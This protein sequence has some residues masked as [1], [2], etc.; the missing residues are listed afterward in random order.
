VH[1]NIESMAQDFDEGSFWRKLS[2]FARRAGR[3]VIER[4]LV[5]YYCM[6][7]PDTPAWA[8]RVIMGALAY[9]VLPV[10][11]VPDILP[12]AG[13][14]DDFGVL[15]SALTIVLT[16]I[17]P[18]HWGQAERKLETWFGR[19]RRRDHPGSNARYTS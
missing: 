7:D 17:K 15:A 2:R 18:D 19:G 11:I 14:A 1:E 3:R 10:D 4:V 8:R 6:Q 16:H 5:L 9:F 12:F 13:F